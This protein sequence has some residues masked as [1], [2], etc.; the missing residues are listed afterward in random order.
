MIAALFAMTTL[1]V[2]PADANALVA[3]QQAARRAGPAAR[4]V[5]RGGTYF[6]PDTLRFDARDSGHTYEAAA[7]EM[8]VISGGR[9]VTGWKKSGDLWEASLVTREPIRDLYVNGRRALRARSPNTGYH[10]GLTSADGLTITFPPGHLQRWS[11]PD[12]VELVTIVEW[13]SAHVSLRGARVDWKKNQITFP[14]LALTFFDMDWAG[15]IRA[16]AP[17]YMYHFE[18]APEMLDAD[19]EWY[20]DRARGVIQYR[21]EKPTEAIATRLEQLILVD[22]ATNLTFRG[23]TFAHSDWKLPANGFL[24]LQRASPWRCKT[25]R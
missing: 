17:H 21:G 2:S 18:N 7:G 22:G 10:T 11:N 8:P 24:P 9:P 14:R 15:H 1:V 5:L 20:F 4:I 13:T 6:L 23:I 12:D 3:A 16:N 19:G 25:R